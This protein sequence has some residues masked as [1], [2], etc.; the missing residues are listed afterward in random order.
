MGT[1]PD[2]LDVPVWSPDSQ[3]IIYSYG[4][5]MGGGNDIRLIE[6]KVDSGA[7]KELSDERFFSI[8]KM[9]WLPDKTG[10]V[11]SARKTF[12]N[13]NQLW[14]VSYPGMET[15]QLTEGLSHYLDLSFA[16][17]ADKAVAS[18]TIHISEIWIGPSRNPKNLRRIS[19]AAPHLS[20]SPDGLLVYASPASGNLD[21]WE[22]RPDGTGQR[23]LTSDAAVDYR[24]AVTPDNRHVVFVSNRTGA[25]QVWRMKRDGS[26]QVQLTMGASHTNPA[27]SPDGRWVL[28]NSTVDWHLWKVP[29]DG[30]DPVQLTDYVA[31][32][33]AVSPDGRL[34]ACVGR[35][36]SR[37]QLL[38]PSSGGGRPLMSFDFA[39]WAPRLQW[40]PD[41]KAVF[42]SSNSGARVA[43]MKQSLASGSPAKVAGFD[44]QEL[45]DFGYSF[46]NR[47][48]AVTQGEWQHDV[49]LIS[50]FARP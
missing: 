37:R 20:W 6:V 43:L 13:N 29:I 19:L 12:G 41:G 18:Q 34:V 28:Y 14:R 36:G 25:F 40:A 24:P 4:N 7:R 26:H 44:A 11:I 30:G 22:M 3:S 31:Y 27:V 21:L 33:P 5:S 47:I 49:V 35:S 17:G 2:N 10:I 32:S 39:E 1:Y 9:A 15:R 42:Y 8:A 46:D 50:G 16:I 38:I 45:F 23:Q 48:L